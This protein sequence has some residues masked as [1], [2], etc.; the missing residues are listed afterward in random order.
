MRPEITIVVPVHNRAEIV[1]GTLRSI[2]AQTFRPLRVILVDNGSTDATPTVLAQWRDA[3]Q[4]PEFTIDIFTET[5]PGATAARNR[6]LREVASPYVMFFDSD[7]I[8]HPQHIQRAMDGFR[9]HSNPDIV[10]W[11]VEIHPLAGKPFTAGFSCTNPQWNN[12]MHGGM[13]TQRYAARTEIIRKAGAWNNDIRGWNDIELGARIL[14]L[15]P[16]LLKLHGKPTVTILQRQ[17]SITG[18]S[19]TQG[20][21]RWEASLDAIEKTVAGDQ[22]QT[23][24][25]RLRRAH[26]A[27]LYAAEGSHHLAQALLHTA[28]AAEPS[29]LH[30]LLLKATATLTGHRIR[31]AISLFRP[32]F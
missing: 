23:R 5:T 24:W 13:S 6:G 4:T 20:A 7:D 15:E 21:G 27:G 12:I 25:V 31:G 1:G 28:T 19:F 10:G 18:Q 3:A 26:L 8:M 17:Q 32:F 14:A 11:D 2:E 16:R 29:H 22:R 9:H 30:R